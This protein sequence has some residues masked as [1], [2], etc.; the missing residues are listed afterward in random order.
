MK[1]NIKPLLAAALALGASQAPAATQFG[2][3]VTFSGFGTL[4]IVQ[5]DSDKEQF[6]R[7]RQ[8][9][10]AEKDIEFDID[11]NVGAQLTAQPTK[12]LSATVQLL[13]MHRDEEN[14]D[15]QTQWAFAKLQPLEGLSIR[16]GRMELP[17]F[18]ISDFRNVGYANTWIRPPDEVYALALLQRLE[19]ADVTYRLPIGSTSLT[20]SVL[21]G[22][23]FFSLN[24]GKTDVGDVKGFNLQWEADWLTV[25][26]GRVK[27]RVAPND[28]NDPYTFSGIGVIVDRG[29]VVAQ[30]EYVTRRSENFATFVDTDGWYVLG[31]YRFGSLLPYLIYGKTEP[32]EDSP[33]HLS[34]EQSTLAAG[35]RWDAF[36][37]AAIKFQVQRVDTNDTPGISFVT[38]TVLGPPGAPPA[39]APVTSPVNVVSLAIDFVF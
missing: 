20:A 31:G 22:K 3:Y 13:A 26:A 11:T 27:A 6:V 34:Y 38:A 17:M 19:G 35:I 16:G 39:T 12:W 28:I 18:A 4:G 32:Q 33:T 8:V 29:N 36:D 9:S 5:T 25:R 30:A 7:D 37:S 2:E 1:A 15:V 24:G 14:I 23:S 21:G 10:G